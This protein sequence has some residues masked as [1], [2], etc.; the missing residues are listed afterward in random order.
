M[1]QGIEVGAGIRPVLD[2]EFVVLLA[3]FYSLRARSRQGQSRR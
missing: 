1:R 3:I 2:I